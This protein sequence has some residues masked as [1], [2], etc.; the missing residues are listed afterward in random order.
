MGWTSWW[1]S[2]GPEACFSSNGRNICTD[3]GGSLNFSPETKFPDGTPIDSAH[4]ALVDPQIGWEVQK[5]LIGWTMVYIPANQKTLWTDQMRLYHLEN[6]VTPEF[7]DRIEWQDP[8][9]GTTYYARTYGMECLFGNANA[10]D[11]A[12]CEIDPNTNQPNGGKWVQKGIGARVL[13]WANYLTGL[14]YS[15][16]K[17]QSNPTYGIGFDAHGRARFLS[18]ADGTA[19]VTPD[20]AVKVLNAAGTKFVPVAPCEPDALGNPQ[21]GCKPLN[22]YK[23]HYAYQLVSYKTVPDYLHQFGEM[24]FANGHVLGQ[25][26]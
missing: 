1:P 26:P 22:Y 3:Y 11:R 23:N 4:T 9:S 2:A 25:Y 6:G 15:L 20:P 16:D 14:G 13:E 17:T 12:S 7:A 19:V 10:I 21:N 18:F 24:F 5:F 8:V